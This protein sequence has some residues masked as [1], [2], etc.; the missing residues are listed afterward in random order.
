[1]ARAQARLTAFDVPPPRERIQRNLG[2]RGGLLH[3]AHAQR[4]RKMVAITP[5]SLVA[6]TLT[7]PLALSRTGRIR[8]ITQV[9]LRLLAHTDQHDIRPTDTSPGFVAR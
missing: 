3:T 2:E 1:M 9:E 6:G 7:S 4:R 5:A 8:E